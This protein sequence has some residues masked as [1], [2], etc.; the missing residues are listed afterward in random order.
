MVASAASTAT[1]LPLKVP[2]KCT[3]PA[4]WVEALHEL[5]RGRRCAAIGKPLAIALP[6]VVTSGSTPAM[7]W[8]RRG[9]AKAG[10]H[11]VEDQQRALAV[12]QVAQALEEAGPREQPGRVVRDRLDDDRGDLLAV[13][14]TAARDVVEVVEAARRGSR[15]WRRRASPWTAGRAGRRARA[16]SGRCAKRSFVG[17]SFGNEFRTR[18]GDGLTGPVLAVDHAGLAR[19]LGCAAH[20]VRDLEELAAALDAA[21]GHDGPTVVVCHVDPRRALPDSGAWWDLGVAAVSEIPETAALATAHRERGRQR[22]FG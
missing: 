8:S 4:G 12:A 14:A 7:A 2:P 20:D 6:R 21:R 11:L 3:S 1:A 10:D 13:S 22:W 17:R 16:R 19:S 18:D 5:A 15:R 9:V